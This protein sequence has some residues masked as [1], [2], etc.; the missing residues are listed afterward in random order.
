[1]TDS[2]LNTI[3]LGRYRTEALL[4]AGGNA[5]VYRAFDLVRKG[6][7]A[8]KLSKLRRTASTTRLLR[9]PDNIN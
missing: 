3:Y 2:L 5:V 1:M 7:V 9:R 4:G 8:L 6:Q